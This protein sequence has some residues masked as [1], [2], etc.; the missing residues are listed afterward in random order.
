MLASFVIFKPDNKK[1]FPVWLM[2]FGIQGLWM[3][4]IWICREYALLTERLIS[5]VLTIGL[6]ANI[7]Y[8]VYCN[9][10]YQ[11]LHGQM[12]SYL[13][14]GEDCFTIEGKAIKLA[15]VHKI[16]LHCEDYYSR[17]TTLRVT[18]EKRLSQGVGNFFE[19]TD[20]EGTHRI[21]FAMYHLSEKQDVFP[22]IERAIILGKVSLL[23]G[24]E[25]MGIHDYDDI[26][27]FKKRLNFG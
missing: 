22:F 18:I 21:Y 4:L 7:G 15:D 19:Y 27:L 6:I 14:F 26:Q 24:T 1:R 23:R 25:L 12:D 9:V 2:Y 5:V 11:T 17:S 20:D 3:F 10:S 8:I 13:V 16:D